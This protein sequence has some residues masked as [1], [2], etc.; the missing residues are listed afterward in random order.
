M[1][2]QTSKTRIQMLF[3]HTHQVHVETG[4]GG[5]SPKGKCDQASWL[6]HILMQPILLTP[7]SISKQIDQQ[8]L[9]NS[10]QVSFQPAT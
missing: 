3:A 7:P 6:L 1:F 5:K 10:W 4:G 2:G 8:T 9:A